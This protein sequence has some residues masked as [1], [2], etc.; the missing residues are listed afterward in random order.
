MKNININVILAVALIALIIVL[1]I[2]LVSPDNPVE[3]GDTSEDT[4]VSAA[5]DDGRTR[6]ITSSWIVP[7]GFELIDEEAGPDHESYVYYNDAIDMKITVWESN[8]TALDY[9]TTDEWLDAEYS[10]F[11]SRT[12]PDKPAYD[13]RN[14]TKIVLSG[15]YSNGT[16]YYI[17][18]A[19]AGPNA[20]SVT[21]EYPSAGDKMACDN[22]VGQFMADY[23]YPQ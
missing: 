19:Q 14:D 2:L 7:E 12:G 17:M 9:D 10:A 23:S 15:Y 1:V 22:T 4:A 6:S 16:V 11:M 20:Y 21:F 5:P 18:E 8:I 3:N 13:Y